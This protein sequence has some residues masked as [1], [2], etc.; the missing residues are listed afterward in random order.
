MALTS[1]V[2]CEYTRRVYADADSYVDED[3]PDSNYGGSDWIL[4][5]DFYVGM[6][7]GFYHFDLTSL[8]TD[9]IDAIITLDFYS[10]SETTDIAVGITTSSWNEITITWNNKPGHGTYH[11]HILNSG[12][13]F[14]FSVANDI[15]NNEISICVYSLDGAGGGY[16]QGTS[17]EGAWSDSN[18]PRI[19]LTYEGI[20]PP[21]LIGIITGIV[22]AIIII[23]AVVYVNIRKRRLKTSV[24][25][26]HTAESTKSTSPASNIHYCI[27]CG[28]PISDGAQYCSKCGAPAY[29]T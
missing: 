20:E 26:S 23:A 28:S 6:C 21:L 3:H 17:R 4:V 12:I 11:G 29:R 5:G 15:Q 7:E 25:S 27:E 9:W 14:S 10:A 22:V 18:I 1:M 24:P 2:H 8:P 16:L 13:K 19:D